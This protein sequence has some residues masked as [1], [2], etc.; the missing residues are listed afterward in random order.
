M[1]LVLNITIVTLHTVQTLVEIVK[2]FG[3]GLL[4][5]ILNWVEKCRTVHVKVFLL[6]FK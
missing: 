5:T 4:F 6:N 3:K 2:Y 1:F